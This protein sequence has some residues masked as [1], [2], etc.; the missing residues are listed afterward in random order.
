MP[1]ATTEI[2]ALGFKDFLSKLKRVNIKTT[3]EE[4]TSLLKQSTSGI[5]SVDDALTSLPVLRER[6]G[7]HSIASRPVG[8]VNRILREGNLDALIALSSRKIPI[9]STDRRLFSQTIG[10]TPEK[11]LKEVGDVASVTKRTHV[12]LDVTPENISKL[13]TNATREVKR[14]ES[15]LFKYFKQGTAIALTVG[16][17]YVGIDWIAKATKERKGCFMLTTINNK[18]TSC[19][20]AAYT[21]DENITGNMCKSIDPYYNVTICLLA[22]ITMDDTDTRKI[23]LCEKLKIEPKDLR[24]KVPSIIDSQYELLSET[25]ATMQSKKE[26]MI[27]PDI[28]KASHPDVENGKIPICRMCSPSD[29]PIST[30]YIDSSQYPDNVTFQ[31]VASPSILDTIADVT[32]ST[33]KDLWSGI[34]GG[35]G[36]ALKNLIIIVVALLGLLIVVGLA[37]KFISS[38]K[39]N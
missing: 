16:L 28:C 33:G 20:V 34:T 12:N 5:K 18:T 37:F 35:L 25:I 39:K 32:V 22:C 24:T 11:S 7:W 1:G 3:T 19:K 21:C 8:Y 6:Q 13:G 17:V 38:R 31:C 4:I 15:N 36:S 10:S 23:F 2:F 27:Y 29:N 30:T 9:G 26:T 14:V